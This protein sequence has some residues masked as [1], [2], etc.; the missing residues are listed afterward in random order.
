MADAPL[1]NYIKQNLENGF[2]ASEIKQALK[3]A[4]WSTLDIEEGFRQTRGQ[5]PLSAKLLDNQNL[6]PQPPP[7]F[8][9]TH[10]TQVFTV[11]VILIA[12]PILGFSGFWIYQKYG[13]ASLPQ[14]STSG[15]LTQVQGTQEIA[16]PGEFKDAQTR[17]ETR[18]KDI[19][20][21]QQTLELYF[22]KH[23]LYPKKISELASEGL[24][25]E[26]PRDPKSNEPYLYRALGD[27]AL[28][29]FLAFVLETK[30]G[31]LKPGLRVVYSQE[32]I[33]PELFQRYQTFISSSDPKLATEG[34]KISKLNQ[35]P[36]LPQ[37]PVTLEVEGIEPVKL[38]SANLIIP[39][40]LEQVD[41]NI[42]LVFKFLAPKNP[43]QYTVYVFGFDS[44]NQGYFQKT[45]LVVESP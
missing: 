44:S 29:Y 14:T 20:G 16:T 18:L 12:L 24:I 33:P 17:D 40:Y 2:A 30:V 45:S 5:N 8:L 41:Q 11:L 35:K 39:G 9:A 7:G 10:K 42:P 3:Q 38:D 26:V 31:N 4:G 22:Q 21:L 19:G 1:L 34:L 6:L 28:Y 23:Q 27:P 13:P 25:A 32:E 37:E 36:F 15:R 43:G